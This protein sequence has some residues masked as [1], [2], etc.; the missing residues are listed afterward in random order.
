MRLK[1]LK[2]LFE[3]KICFCRA[4]NFKPC[5]LRH[6]ILYSCC[7]LLFIQKADGI[8]HPLLKLSLLNFVKLRLESEVQF[9][10][11]YL[12]V[13]ITNLGFGVIVVNYAN[14]VFSKSIACANCPAFITT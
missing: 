7:N 9:G 6:N 13:F 10:V 1:Y 8:S 4:V 11:N 2:F 5:C 14:D 3:L 12:V